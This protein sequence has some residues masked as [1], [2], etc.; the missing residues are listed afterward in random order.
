[1]HSDPHGI[2]HSDPHGIMHSD[3]HGSMGP[4][5]SMGGPGMPDKPDCAKT[6]DSEA[7]PTCDEFHAMLA[8]G[9]CAQT[10]TEAEKHIFEPF[11]CPPPGMHPPMHG[12]G[13]SMGDP[14]MPES[15]ECAKTCDSE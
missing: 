10:C 6:C 7:H 4:G 5:P 12:P 3:P 14:G 8:P 11:F 2:M 1:M 13:P 9:G 15:P